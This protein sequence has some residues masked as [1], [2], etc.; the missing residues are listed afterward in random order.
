MLRNPSF[1]DYRVAIGSDGHLFV[2]G[3][4]VQTLEFA[5]TVS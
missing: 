2:K 5:R 3:V 1:S 4:I